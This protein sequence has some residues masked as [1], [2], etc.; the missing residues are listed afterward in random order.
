MKIKPWMWLAGG[1]GAFIF[2]KDQF[3]PVFKSGQATLLAG[4]TYELVTVQ[5]GLTLIKRL[6]PTQDTVF[7]IDGNL[8]KE[9]REV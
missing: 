3:K 9:I 8:I 6:T 4:H 1:I 2:L 7:T 5:G